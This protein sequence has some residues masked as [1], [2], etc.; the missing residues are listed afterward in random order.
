[1]ITNSSILRPNFEFC[2]VR[3]I[4]DQRW[5]GFTT[6]PMTEDYIECMIDRWVWFADIFMNN[7]DKFSG[8]IRYNHTF[9][10]FTSFDS[11]SFL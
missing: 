4:I 2:A 10:S 1:M 5:A 7:R 8:F 9:D 11:G 6:D 3:H